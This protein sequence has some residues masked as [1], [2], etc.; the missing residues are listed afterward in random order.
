MASP[1]T[2][3]ATTPTVT[4]LD[5]SAC[6][7]ARRQQQ[8]AARLR[9][10]ISTLD[11]LIAEADADAA[12]AEGEQEAAGGPAASGSEAPVVVE[13]GTSAMAIADPTLVRRIVDMIN[14]SYFAALQESTGTERCRCEKAG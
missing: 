6:L 11:G 13:I 14:G 12:A 10:T 4:F 1:P 8:R 5:S 7:R 2:E 3:A 9:S